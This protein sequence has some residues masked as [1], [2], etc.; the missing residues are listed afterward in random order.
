MRFSGGMHIGIGLCVQV[1]PAAPAPEHSRRYE[2]EIGLSLPSNT[3]AQ[4]AAPSQVPVQPV[5]APSVMPVA[6]NDAAAGNSSEQ[7]GPASE[8]LA[9]DRAQAKV[10]N[11]RFAQ[12]CQTCK[13]RKY[14]DG[15][16]DPGVSFKSPAHIDP[17][18]AASVVMGHEQ[19]HVVH[20]KAKAEQQGGEVI[21]QSVVLH[22]A[23]CPECGRSYVAGGTTRT[24]TSTPQ[25]KSSPY[26]S[27]EQVYATGGKVLDGTA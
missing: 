13:N 7:F 16:N 20:E 21:S 22:S 12:A 18:N 17:A 2:M 4:P 5:A 14:Q 11:D 25:Q 1:L 10:M 3:Y 23:V 26:A 27:Y 8:Q 9:R 24:V 15:S 6:Q 19:E